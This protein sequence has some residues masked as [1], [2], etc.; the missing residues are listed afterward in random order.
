GPWQLL[1][2]C[3]LR[4]GEKEKAISEAKHATEVSPASAGAWI[5]LARTE[6]AAGHT[7]ET[8]HAILRAADLL[9]DSAYL[10]ESVGYGYIN[11]D[12]I[13]EA[14]PPLQ[15]AAHFAPN[16]FLIHAQLGF[17]LETTGQTNAAMEHLRTAAKLNPNY[18]PVWEHLGLAYVQ[19]GRH[20]EA[21]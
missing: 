15:R 16:D 12:R 6:K 21:V 1:S 4:L 3:H 2:A 19:Q 17:C 13:S 11:L 20:R 9:P 14:I 18:A 8:L 5:Q 7:S 10:L